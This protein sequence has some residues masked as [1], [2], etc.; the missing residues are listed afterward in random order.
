M[1][2]EGFGIVCLHEPFSQAGDPLNQTDHPDDKSLRVLNAAS[3]VFLEHGFNA[4]TT[5]MIQRAAGV[6]KATVYSRYPNKEALFA[7]VIENQCNR[8]TRQVQQIEVT[9]DNIRRVLQE[10]G[11]TYLSLLLSSEAL[12][13]Y[14]VVVAV[15]DRFPH[16]AHTFYSS[17]PGAMTRILAAHLEKAASAGEIDVQAVGLEPAATLFMSMLRGEAQLIALTHPD[18]RASDVQIEQWVNQA[19]TTFLRAYGTA[20]TH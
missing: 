5:D 7:A 11:H 14:R 17:G 15:A 1:S 3:R 20:E 9:P 10:I 19:V 16:L 13:L 2:S 8:F 12:A 4:A 6:S 18:S